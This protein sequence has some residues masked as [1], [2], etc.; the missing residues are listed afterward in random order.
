EKM[1]RLEAMGTYTDD[2][3][4]RLARVGK[5]LSRVVPTGVAGS[6]TTRKVSTI[7]TTRMRMAMVILNSVIC[8]EDNLS[9]IATKL[10][11]PLM[12]DSYISDMYIQSWDR[13]SYARALTEVQA[14]V[15]L[16]DTI[17][18]AMPKHTGE[19]LIIEGKVT[20]VDDEGKPLKMVDSS[21]DYDSEDEI[22]SVDSDMANFLSSKKD[23]YDQ[24]VPD[25]IQGI[26]DNFDITIRSRKKKRFILVS[27]VV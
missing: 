27:F 25:K 2:E 9:V 20:L 22:A 23:G 19:R 14:D 1:R 11:N 4:N 13:S 8:G 26:C 24:D 6:G 21:G 18:V 12:I 15:K 10:G 17:V 7:R 3:I 5:H 16:K